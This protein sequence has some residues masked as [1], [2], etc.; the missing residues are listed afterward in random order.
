MKV[1]G[2]EKGRVQRAPGATVVDVPPLE[3]GD[4]LTRREF[5]RRYHPL[6]KDLV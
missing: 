5:E 6:I 3:S 4:R 1:G 2:L